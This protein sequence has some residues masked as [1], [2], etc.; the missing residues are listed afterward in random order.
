MTGPSPSVKG[1]AF[2]SQAQ[3]SGRNLRLGCFA[4]LPAHQGGA[5]RRL[6]RNLAGLEIHFVRADDLELHPGVCGEV[7]ELYPAQKAYSVFWKDVWVNHPGM[8]QNPLQE[9][10]PADGPGLFP[11]CL[12]VSCILTPV[13][14]CAGLGEVLPHLGIDHVD[15]MIQLGRNLVV[16]L[17]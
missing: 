15:K 16:S 12:T 13:S 11:P 6:Q 3:C 5:Y 7:G 8:L 1:D 4:D 9:T 14:L 17:L 2:Y 10:D